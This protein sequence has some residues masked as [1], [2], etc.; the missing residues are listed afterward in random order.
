MTKPKTSSKQYEETIT[1][2]RK[3]GGDEIQSHLES[4][5][6]AVVKRRAK[7]VKKLAKPGTAG[8]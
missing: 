1:A 5:L 8:G 3:A 7:A 4:R 2:A 6:Q